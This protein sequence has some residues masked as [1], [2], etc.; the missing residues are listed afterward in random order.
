MCSLDDLLSDVLYFLLS[1]YQRQL[2]Y[3]RDDGSFSAFGDS[4]TSG[5]TW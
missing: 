2:S 1:G 3:Q 5:S 4:D